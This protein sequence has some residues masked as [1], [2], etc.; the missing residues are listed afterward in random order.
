MTTTQIIVGSVV[1]GAIAGTI[2]YF[3]TIPLADSSKIVDSGTKQGI[4]LYTGLV[5]AGIIGLVS[6]YH[7]SK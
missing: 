2:Q 5:T 6:Y 7:A 1:I 3:I 4:S